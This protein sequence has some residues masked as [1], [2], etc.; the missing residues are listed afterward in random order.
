MNLL[1][2][3]VLLDS[4]VVDIINKIN[5]FISSNILMYGLLF[6]G[7]FLS[8]LLGFPQITK[9]GKAFKL[10]FG[11]LF[12]KNEQDK[13]QGS[14]SSFQALATAVA[15]QVGTGNVAGVATAI[16]AGGPGAV[17]WMWIS[18]FFGM[19]TIFVEAVL[20]QKYRS[21]INGELVGGPA[22]YISKGLKKT[23]LFAKIL[24]GFFSVAIVLALGFMGNAV[25]SNSI[26]FGI[27]GIEG[28]SKV[29]PAIIGV[30]IAILAA[31]IFIGGLSRIAKFAELVVPI[32]AVVY[33]AGS[34][35]ILFMF[36]DRIIPT[37]AWIFKSAFSPSAVAGG[38]AGAAVKAAVQKGVARGL[39]SNEAGMGSTPHAHAVANVKHP[40]EQGLSAIIGVFIDTILVCSATAL[41]ILL[42]G[43]YNIKGAD[44]NYLAGAQ[45]TQGAFKIAFGEAGAIFLAVCLSFFAF[46]TIIG[47][48]YFGES[49]IKYLFGNKGLTP[50]RI[51]VI[52]CIIAGSLG[53]VNIVWSLADIFNS[54]MVL[55]N[56]IAIIW[57]SF[58]ARDILKDYKKKLKDGNIDYD[59][60]VK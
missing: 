30:I 38:I 13:E 12:K 42:T 32:M 37:F 15:A 16:T 10:V 18:A 43:A 35:V 36:S 21:R 8:I 47:W 5:D 48:Y 24:A 2:N 20:A 1:S 4:N 6:A 55:P 28:L 29:N 44:G 45:L 14:M 40:A 22:Y 59:Y 57:L 54:L 41:A 25:Q 52:I 7:L 60:L 19:S 51:I 39:F 56:L 49:N 11:G 23:G 58:E 27:K 33:I 26:A 9:I 34:I 50:Y 46:T 31:L 3:F 53:K 17:F